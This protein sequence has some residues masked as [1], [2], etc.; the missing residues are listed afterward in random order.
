MASHWTLHRE[1]KNLGN[2][3]DACGS[4]MVS[5]NEQIQLFQSTSHHTLLERSTSTTSAL[6]ANN[7]NESSLM[8]LM[9]KVKTI[10]NQLNNQP[11]CINS[12]DIQWSFDQ[13]I[14]TIVK[15][16]KGH[17]DFIKSQNDICFNY[18]NESFNYSTLFAI[19]SRL[20][21]WRWAHLYFPK[22]KT[23]SRLIISLFRIIKLRRFVR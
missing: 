21:P 11:I 7:V 12:F 8:L 2:H 9:N 20:C 16:Q 19:M 1:G 18:S 4:F 22:V 6:N 17:Q 3:Q 5:V 10:S 14:N 23:Y 15:S 13:P